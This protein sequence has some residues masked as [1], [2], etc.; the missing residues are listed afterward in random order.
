MNTPA[1]SRTA[2][3]RPSLADWGVVAIA[4]LVLALSFSARSLLGLAMPSLES[5]LGWSRSL[6]SSAG[7][8]AL[9]VMAG[10]APLTGGMVDRFGARWIL[11]A[12]LA[13][14]GLG[15]VLTAGISASWQFFLSFSLLAGL[16]FGMAANHVVATL[17]SRRF[18]ARRGL[19]VGT[20]T[21][22]S[23]AGQLLVV[24]LLAAVMA[25]AGAWRSSYLALG[26]ACLALIPVAWILIGRNGNGFGAVAQGPRTVARAAPPA[27]PLRERLGTVFGS[28]TF[29]LLAAG[30]FI[31]GVTTTG[32]IETHLLPY[33]AACGFPPLS[34]A[35]AYGVLSA[36]NL[37]GMVLAGHLS[38]R[39]NRP[40]LLGGLYVLRG[41]SFILLMF[42]AR[43]LS[44]L[45]VFAV[46][47]GIFDYSTFVVTASLVSTH[48]GLRVMGLAMGLLSASHSLGGA[49]G[50]FAGGYLFDL[51]ARY[52]WVWVASV[53]LALMAGLFS[54]AIRELPD[55]AGGRLAPVVAH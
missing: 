4:F 37:I 49:L 28:A 13:T 5:E 24:P 48:V 33:A 31:C 53:L 47:F 50:A 22:G 19:A 42:I 21:S 6:V 40:L 55:R 25:A 23:T 52:E 3:A 30:F 2:F 36:F 54:F 8:T 35:T 29:W 46:L 1:S 43:D 38:D 16:G 14:V 26:I 34:S 10:V 20:A 9:L 7:A 17:V 39:M 27:A 51:F 32:V 45:F 18:E 11:C 12:G 44:L 41:L 15:M